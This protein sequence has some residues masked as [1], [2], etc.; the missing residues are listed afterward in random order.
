MSGTTADLAVFA[1][2]RHPVPAAHAQHLARALVDTVGCALAATPSDLNALLRSWCERERTT[3]RSTV[4]T[5][6]AQV[7]AAQAALLNGTAGHALDW[8][9][10]SPGGVLHPS[11]VLLPALLAEAEATGASGPALT[12]AH[13]VGAA[14]FR[15][16]TQALPRSV[17]YG[18][19]WHTT[20]TVGR[21]ATVAA[22]ANLRRLDERQA[23]N[24]LGLVASLAS[25]SLANFGTMT[26][27]LHAGVAARDA[28][29]AV[30]LAAEGFTSN[31]GQLE[32]PGGFF[33]LFGEPDGARLA[34]LPVE[35]ERWRLEW[36]QDWALKRYPACYATHRAVDAALS[37]RAGLDGR[38]PARVEVV[39]EPGGLRPL[40]S[41]EPATATEAKFSM[42]YAVSV[43]LAHG[44]L[45]LGHFSDDGFRDEAARAHI[46]SVTVR[47]SD[48]PPLGEPEF[49][50]GYTVVSVESP[51]GSIDRRR[52]D[53][54]YGDARS[55]LS[56]A[57]LDAKFA[58]CCREG[59]LSLAATGR[60][61]ALLR[62]VPSG[63]G[64]DQLAAALA[65]EARVGLID[66]R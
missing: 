25:G 48:V 20:S 23:C 43:A 5:T 14:V 58:D 41:S 11:V 27:P 38:P 46:G 21:V 65:G 51:S 22:L 18:R 33:A 31:I 30:E 17:H 3:G 24:A 34:R 26:K 32:A 49:G 2:T 16:V 10:V 9:D 4:W 44:E 36:P 60:L 7:S 56:E 61:V 29:T 50:D 66:A 45:R 63:A 37:L 35:L 52:V 42:A 64:L 15:A 59:G 55:P 53:H 6:G 1:C 57:D 13:D 62:A 28:V 8:D 19:G 47:E 40:L 54:T 12:Q 39:V